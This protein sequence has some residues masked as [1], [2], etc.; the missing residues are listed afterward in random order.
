M[1]VPVVAHADHGA[2]QGAHG[3]EQV[4]VPLRL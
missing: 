2:V 1:T 4:A 3:R